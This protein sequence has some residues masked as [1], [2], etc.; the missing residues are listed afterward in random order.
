MKSPGGERLLIDACLPHLKTMGWEVLN[1]LPVVL[2]PLP[3]QLERRTHERRES[4]TRNQTSDPAESRESTFLAG[5]QVLEQVHWHF[6]L[7]QTDVWTCSEE[8]AGMTRRLLR[9]DITDQER[10]T[11]ILDNVCFTVLSFLHTVFL[12]FQTDSQMSARIWGLM[13]AVLQLRQVIRTV[14]AHTLNQNKPN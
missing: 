2:W 1:A 9:A 3:S 6:M 11:W 13:L 8:R 14:P 10:K 5:P 4:Q 7:L 12:L